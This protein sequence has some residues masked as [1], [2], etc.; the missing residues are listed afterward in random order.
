MFHELARKQQRGLCEMFV[1]DVKVRSQ[2]GALQLKCLV[3]LLCRG[4]CVLLA[5]S[6]CSWTLHAAQT[7]NNTHANKHTCRRLAL[8]EENS[9]E[10]T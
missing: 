5:H 1:A 4:L 9:E 6:Q 7:H 2:G 3:M 10:Y 8:R